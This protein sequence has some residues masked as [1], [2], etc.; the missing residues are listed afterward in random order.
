MR[1]PNWHTRLLVLAICVLGLAGCLPAPPGE[2][3]VLDG[4]VEL[5]LK[6]GERLPGTPV[7]LLSITDGTARL[8]IAGIYAEKKM[9]DSL[10]WSG[11]VREGVELKLA[12][13]I[14]WIA[15]DELH[16]AGTARIRIQRP[17]PAPQT[18]TSEPPIHYALPMTTTVRRD[19]VLPGSTLTYLG[20]DP[21]KGALF[22]GVAGY[23]Y[24]KVADS[25][26]WEGSLRDGVLARHDLRVIFFTDDQAQLG[27][28]IHIYITPE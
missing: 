27:G 26:T 8:R 11:T 22:G 2:T 17:N 19:Q 4:P 13:R 3:L 20:K 6:V 1:Q 9:G 28:I 16:T 15:E 23:P 21:E 10:D 5:G 14:L 24:R 18:I 7:E 25:L 12:L